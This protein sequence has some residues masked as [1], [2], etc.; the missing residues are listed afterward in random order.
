MQKAT[1]RVLGGLL[2]AH[3]VNPNPI[4]VTKAKGLDFFFFFFLID[5]AFF[6]LSRNWRCSV[7]C[8]FYFSVC[9]SSPNIRLEVK[10]R[11]WSPD[12]LRRV[13]HT[14]NGVC[15]PF[16]LDRRHDVRRQKKT[17]FFFFFF[18]L[19]FTDMQMLSCELF[20]TFSTLDM[21]CLASN[22]TST[23]ELAQ[24]S[25]PWVED[26]ILGTNILRKCTCCLERR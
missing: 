20:E 3:A 15:L 10:E 25:S 23:P 19:R 2:G 6:F 21:A 16:R 24:E 8:N 4:L 13:G 18:R 26:Q 17:I 7:L 12:C 9:I 5:C 22:A 14:A 1:I 11:F